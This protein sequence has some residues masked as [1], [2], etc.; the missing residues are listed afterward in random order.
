MT[1]VLFI[2]WLR[3][4]FIPWNENLCRKFQYEGPIVLFLDGHATH[5]T[6]RVLAYACSERILI[7]RLVAH[8]SHLGQPL[9]L[10]VLA[11]RQ[12]LYKKEK[13]VN[14]MKGDRPKL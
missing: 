12:I 10:C 8:S 4:V 1:E 13:N 2:D 11:I 5:V 6:D 9:D 7:I 14:G 3:T